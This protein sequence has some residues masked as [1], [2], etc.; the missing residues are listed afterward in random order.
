MYYRYETQKED[1][2]WT[3]VCAMFDPSQRRK[4]NRFIHVPKWYNENGNADKNS[5][6][7]LTAEGFA[8][9]A[10]LFT[11]LID[12]TRLI[13]RCPP[14]R[15]RVANDL[16]NIVMRGKIQVINLEDND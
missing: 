12:Q 11:T 4:L 5:T 16:P 8:K 6:C 2:T 7:W 14:V 3:G 15:L 9:Y 1:G 13:K 10:V